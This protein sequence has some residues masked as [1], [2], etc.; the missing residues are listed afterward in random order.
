MLQ[1]SLSASG[2]PS[3]FTFPYQSEFGAS[4]I[5]PFSSRTDRKDALVL[6]Q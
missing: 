5:P 6:W 3:W 1:P 4:L 2:Y